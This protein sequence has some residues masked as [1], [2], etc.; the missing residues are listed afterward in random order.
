MWD[1][2][3]VVVTTSIVTLEN[4]HQTLQT[5]FDVNTYT[6][7]YHVLLLPRILHNICTKN[8]PYCPCCWVCYGPGLLWKFWSYRCCGTSSDKLSR[9]HKILDSISFQRLLLVLVCYGN[10]DT[11]DVVVLPGID[12]PA[13]IKYWTAYLFKDCF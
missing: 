1:L 11:T 7:Y 4:Q 9:F 13:F 2:E 5:V 10:S 6:K 8:R 12:R 3:S